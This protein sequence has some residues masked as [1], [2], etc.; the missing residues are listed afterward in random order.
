MKVLRLMFCGFVLCLAI[1]VQANPVPLEAVDEYPTKVSGFMENIDIAIKDGPQGLHAEFLGDYQIATERKGRLAQLWATL[2]GRKNQQT[3]LFPVPTNAQD[4]KV[5]PLTKRP[6]LNLYD[7]V[8]NSYSGRTTAQPLAWQW[9]RKKYPTIL[10]EMPA[11]PVVQWSMQTEPLD[12]YRVSRF[13]VD[14]KHDLIRR[15]DDQ[16]LFYAMG[17][18]KGG[19]WRKLNHERRELSFEIYFPDNFFVNGL[20]LDKDPIPYYFEEN[21]LGFGLDSDITPLNR[22]LIV[23]LAPMPHDLRVI[24]VLPS[25]LFKYNSTKELRG[26][27]LQIGF[28]KFIKPLDL[29]QNCVE[30][31]R[32]GGD[33]QFGNGNDVPVR[34]FD[35]EFLQAKAIRITINDSHNLNDTCRL[36]LKAD[37][38]NGAD[39]KALNGEN[40][41]KFPSGD[42]EPGG[43][44][45]FT[46]NPVTDSMRQP[47]Y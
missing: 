28:S 41:G 15:G 16:L 9:S 34:D 30:L 12:Q 19:G 3:I 40:N 6:W 32:S 11:A 42:S 7:N 21:R 36:R 45:V 22:D 10:E 5:T 43:D 47:F 31:I 23:S 1:T 46:F 39:G 35:V 25:P 44:F 17:I 2:T 8:R 27:F 13:L 33:G 24:T 18:W 4:I 29:G 38:M 37:K 20:F 14:Y 26:C